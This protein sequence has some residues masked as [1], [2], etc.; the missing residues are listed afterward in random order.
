MS[1]AAD[2]DI[3]RVLSDESFLASSMPFTVGL[4][5]GRLRIMFR[6]LLFRFTDDYEL[7]VSREQDGVRVELAGR[8]SRITITYRAGGSSVEYTIEYR[9]PRSW[10]ARRGAERLARELLAAAKREASRRAAS[11]ERRA[12]GGA[13]YSEALSSI[14]W[15]TRLIMK[16][17]LVKSD[18]VNLAPGG[19]HHYLEGL[20]SSGEVSRYRVVYVSGTGESG[21]FKALFID[22]ELRGVYVNASGEEASGDE[23]ALS[24]LQGF[25]N[26]RVY[27][28]MLSP[29]EVARL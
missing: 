27:G 6:R 7:H 23:K 11:R 9:G 24:R 22:G 28:S 25:F 20:L 16:S 19:L 14:S 4:S 8:R 13:D 10:I 26:V 17:I 5:G 21:S 29:E 2:E 15:T 1:D 18:V 3:L 12:G